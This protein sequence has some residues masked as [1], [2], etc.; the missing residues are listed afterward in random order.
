[1][2]G[3]FLDCYI[4]TDLDDAPPIKLMA[5]WVFYECEFCG[6]K[7]KE[8]T[9][10]MHSPSETQCSECNQLSKNAY[11]WLTDSSIIDEDNNLINHQVVIL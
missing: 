11:R 6:C 8:T 3:D 7:W 1:M 2:T 4:N 5:G 9:K 10:D